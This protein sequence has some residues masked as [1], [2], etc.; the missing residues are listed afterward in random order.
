MGAER[1]R[2]TWLDGL[3]GFGCLLVILGHVLSG[4]LDAGTFPGFYGPLYSLRSWIYSFHMPLFFLL[5]G[6]TFTLAYYREDHLRR[7]G[8]FRQLLNLLWIYTLFALLQWGLKQLVPALVNEPYTLEDLLHMFLEPLGNFWYVYILFL[9]YLAAAVTGLPRRSPL[10]LVPLCVL[11]VYVAYIHLDWTAL[12]GYRFLYHLFFFALGCVLCKHRSALAHPKLLG[13]SAMFLATA[14]FF[15]CFFY[16]RNWYASWKVTIAAATCY[17]FLWEFLRFPRLSGWVLF[18]NFGKYAL[19]VYLL[20][21]FFTGGFRT[22][23]P[24]LGVSTP[25]LSVW[26]NFLCSA[27]LSYLLA[28]LLHRLRLGNLLFRPAQMRKKELPSSEAPKQ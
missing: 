17:V 8:F 13:L 26:L 23:L 22:L 20:H 3:K 15:Y 28:V 27:G 4:Y 2:E 5:S 16:T 11:S 7:D 9:F 6:F 24:L 10:W 19:E 18:Q 12:T 1:R 14:A 25:F 21:T